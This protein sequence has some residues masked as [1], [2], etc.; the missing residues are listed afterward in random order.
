MQVETNSNS[1]GLRWRIKFQNNTQEER[2]HIIVELIPDGEA[3]ICACVVGMITLQ[4]PNEEDIYLDFTHI[5]TNN[6][7]QTPLLT[8]HKEH[9]SG[10][11]KIQ[12]LVDLRSLEQVLPYQ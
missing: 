11:E 10:M 3:E 7:R 2:F 8:A 5:F 12:V 9:F 4:N 6:Q 1:E